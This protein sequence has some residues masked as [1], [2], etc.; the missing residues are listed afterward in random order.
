MS[1][2]F[3]SVGG[4]GAKIL[5][6]LTH[7]TVAGVLPG[8]KELNVIALDPD[9][10]NGNLKRTKSTLEQVEQFQDARVGD[11]TALLKN[12]VKVWQP[13]PFNP[14]PTIEGKYAENLDEVMSADI[15]DGKDSFC[16]QPLGQLYKVLYSNKERR[17]PLDVGFRGHPSIGAAV[18][19]KQY[20]QS[21]QW[22]KLQEQIHNE[23][24]NGVSDVKVFLAGSIF[25]G[26][27]AAGLPT[28]AHLLRKEFNN[29]ISIGGVLMLPYF[30]FSPKDE[31][32]IFAKSENFLTN[33][34]AALKYY[35]QGDKDFDEMY[36]LG[37]NAVVKSDFST[38]GPQQE[39]NAHI[40]DLYGALAAIDFFGKAPAPAPADGTLRVVHYNH[41]CRNNQ[42]EFVWQDL[43]G[44]TSGFKKLFVQFCRFVLTYV[45]F[46]K[47]TLDNPPVVDKG[48]VYDSLEW[49]GRDK[50][51]WYKPIAYD[52]HLSTNYL[53]SDNNK[54]KN[55]NHYIIN[56]CTWLKQLETA[57]P[58]GSVPN[59]RTVSLV[60]PN[61]FK[62]VVDK[63][64]HKH[65][66]VD[67]DLFKWCD[68]TE[69]G[70]GLTLDA[71]SHKLNDT[72]K[73]NS[74]AQGF[75]KLLRHVYGSC[76]KTN[77]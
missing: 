21:E 44:L 66:V 49:G 37:D 77:S 26:T 2:Y 20:S 34:K 9:T 16:D 30:W 12:K 65:I 42:N 51:D 19:A 1:Y 67:A 48:I 47:P 56:Y 74:N 68:P 69:H 53:E 58:D 7:L 5:E 35:S 45:Q 27:G 14:L 43:E 63:K 31:E 17:T 36:F 61:L 29:S 23:T 62:I 57:A 6:A 25:G 33:A 50:N 13:L 22:N 4:T 10:G 18:L 64:K 24:D 41:I 60:N 15:I 70:S 3:I 72:S 54:I 46:I 8:N 52:K 11:G 32:G 75:G 71:I 76:D 38:G 55:F 39:N 59:G 73:L 28:I 40:V